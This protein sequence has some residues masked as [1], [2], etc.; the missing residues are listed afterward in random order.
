MKLNINSDFPVGNAAGWCKTEG[1]VVKLLESSAQFVVV[2]SITLEERQGNPGNTFN[3]VDLNSLG[4]PN[5]GI[6]NV[7][8][9]LPGVIHQIPKT[10]S[11]K[12]ILSLAGFSPGDFAKLDKR[13]LASGISHREINLGCPNVADGGT[14]K[15]IA[16]LD[17]K[18]TEAVLDVIVENWTDYGDDIFTSVK[19]SP[20]TDPNFILLLAELIAQY[21]IDAV[22]TQNTMP[23]ALL[24]NEDG[25]TQIQTPDGTGWAGFAG[26]A[27]HPFALGQVNQWRK[28]L[29][30]LGRQ[31]IEVHGVGGVSDGRNVRDMLRAGASAVQVGTAYFNVGPKV[32]GDIASE[33]ISL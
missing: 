9:W 21:P 12:V 20:M 2:G 16:S 8:G 5:P 29:N 27:V 19:I 15:R 13:A 31:D 25:S 32:F 26:P 14:R 33:Y 18:S 7:L 10:D 6:S 1:E 22:V 24:F 28:A 4:L 30:E 17:L 11:R 23:N 3:G